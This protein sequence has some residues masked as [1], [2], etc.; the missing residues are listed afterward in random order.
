MK[1]RE[2][3]VLL[4]SLKIADAA[5]MALLAN[6][7]KIWD[8]V[9]D[10]MPYPYGE[11]NGREFIEMVHEE[12]RPLTFGISYKGRLAGVISLV[13]QEDIY[14]KTAEIGYWLGEPFWGK[15]IAT[16][17]VKMITKYGFEQMDFIRLYAGIFE[18]NIGSMRVLEKNGYVKEGIF[19]KALIKNNQ[20]WD[21]H[22]YALLKEDF[23][24]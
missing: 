9:R 23:A 10:Y 6:N 3:Q 17:A 12:E 22:R 2:N 18:Y 13:A 7:K 8:N 1:I 24:G 20:I 15:G 5:P 14:R 21:E 4:R 16:Q 19:K 11:Q